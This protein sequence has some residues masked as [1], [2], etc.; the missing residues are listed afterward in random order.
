MPK[1]GS[2]KG[3]K[4]KALETA[5]EFTRLVDAKFLAR[6]FGITPRTVRSLA[7]KGELPS[8]IRIGSRIRWRMEDILDFEDMK[9]GFGGVL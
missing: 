3:T 6:H 4:Y 9:A 1:R 5:G 7:R 2:V 8:G